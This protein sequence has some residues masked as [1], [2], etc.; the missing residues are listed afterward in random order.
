MDATA[1]VET[2]STM[3]GQPMRILGRA[4]KTNVVHFPRGRDDSDPMDLSAIDQSHLSPEQFFAVWDTLQQWRDIYRSGAVSLDIKRIGSG[5]IPTWGCWSGS[6][7]VE[8][9]ADIYRA[10]LFDQI[11]R[12]HVTNL[13]HLALPPAWVPSHPAEIQAKAMYGHWRDATTWIPPER[14]NGRTVW[15]STADEPCRF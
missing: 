5:A 7:W 6:E 10:A 1:S 15:V 11:G 13:M 2:P 12:R 9:H 8:R 4:R 3:K 14:L